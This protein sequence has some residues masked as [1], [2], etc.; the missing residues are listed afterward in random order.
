V[1]L[2]VQL[3]ALPVAV[4]LR[5]PQ[6]CTL[7]VDVFCCLAIA[8]RA[9]LTPP[10]PGHA[11]SWNKN[12]GSDMDAFLKDIPGRGASG[13][14]ANIYDDLDTTPVVWHITEVRCAWPRAGP[15]QYFCAIAWA[16]KDSSL[17]L[18]GQSSAQSGAWFQCTEKKVVCLQ[19]VDPTEYQNEWLGD[20]VKN[21]LPLPL[22]LIF[23]PLISPTYFP[24]SHARSTSPCL[25]HSTVRLHTLTLG[26]LIL[27][28]QHLL[29]A[30][31][32]TRRRCPRLLQ[33]GEGGMGGG[34]F[35]CTY[36]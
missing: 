12:W 25:Q 32:H 10:L 9:S 36:Y 34:G 33:K 11:E 6:V 19:P 3:R 35:K 28:D 8:L 17:F 18:C 26:V 29:G 27:A 22:S 15:V 21:S 30:D 31:S 4:F 1:D 2:A 20:V 16:E 5:A 23:S 13:V 24:C 7:P 14:Y